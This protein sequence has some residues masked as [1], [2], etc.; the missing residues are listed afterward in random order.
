MLSKKDNSEF[1]VTIS[2]KKEIIKEILGDISQKEFEKF[3]KDTITFKL[4][5]NQFM[6]EILKEED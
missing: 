5:N 2:I 1:R 6:P 3:C 4:Y